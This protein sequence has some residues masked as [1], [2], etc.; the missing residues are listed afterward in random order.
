MICI[1]TF[2]FLSLHTLGGSWTHDLTLDL[3]LAREECAIGAKVHCCI[4]YLQ[5]KLPDFVYFSKLYLC[6]F[7]PF[8]I[9]KDTF[10][11]SLA[12]PI[13]GEG[14]LGFLFVFCWGESW[15]EEERKKYLS[16]REYKNSIEFLLAMRILI[17]YNQKKWNESVQ[18]S[19]V[20]LFEIT[21]AIWLAYN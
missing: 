9:S 20:Y 16:G 17:C 2:L 14:Q 3:D 18:N 19:V 21:F 10:P 13:E 6:F 7:F 15:E 8:Q 1:A 12:L 11:Y 5:L 4:W